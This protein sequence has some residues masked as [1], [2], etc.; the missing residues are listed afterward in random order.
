MAKRKSYFVSYLLFFIL[1]I[2]FITYVVASL[3]FWIKGPDKTS[4]TDKVFSIKNADHV[5]YCP[6]KSDICNKIKKFDL[7]PNNSLS[8]KQKVS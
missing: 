3:A 8:C 2:L 4:L 1:A 6:D 7:H 5:I